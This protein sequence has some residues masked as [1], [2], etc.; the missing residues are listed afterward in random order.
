MLVLVPLVTPKRLSSATLAS[1]AGLSSVVLWTVVTAAVAI[2]TSVKG[3]SFKP[4]W[5]PDSEALG[6]GSVSLQTVTA[7]ATLPVIATAFTCQ[8]TVAFIINELRGGFSTHRITLV[9]SVAVSLCTAVFLIIGM[10][11]ITAFSPKGIP[12]DILEL[13]SAGA[14]EGIIGSEI[15]AK[16]IGISVRLG[17]MVSILANMPLQML[18]FR[19][20][21][22]RLVF[23]GDQEFSGLGYY[24]VTYG[25]VVAFYFIAMAARS[26]WVPIQ[27]VG[28]TA[29]AAIAFFYPA[30]VAL[31]VDN[32]MANSNYWRVNAW[33]LII[34]GIVQVLTGVSAV[35]FIPGS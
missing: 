9:S 17:F 13:F 19:Q 24:G 34:I 21:L 15:V 12:A 16:I 14:L 10:G 27:L 1:I 2:T 4:S 26:I 18:P 29:G 23:R 6:G 33:G 31:N 20:S 11:S 22:A 30:L 8:M 7:L 5:L 32:S 25:S 35:L 28:A 3:I